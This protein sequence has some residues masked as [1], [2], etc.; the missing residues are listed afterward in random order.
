MRGKVPL[1]GFLHSASSAL[2]RDPCLWGFSE[3]EGVFLGIRGGGEGIRWRIIQWE[4]FTQAN[5]GQT[6]REVCSFRLLWS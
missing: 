1:V 4:D 5:N 3:F 6:E 2:P